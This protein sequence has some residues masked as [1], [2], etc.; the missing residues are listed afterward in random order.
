M[1]AATVITTYSTFTCML[2][3]AQRL[4]AW[5]TP[6]VKFVGVHRRRDISCVGR[7]LVAVS[8]QEDTLSHASSSCARAWL[9]FQIWEQSSTDV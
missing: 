6:S 4:R 8:E 5:C 3:Y 9:A 7:T 1:A 2:L